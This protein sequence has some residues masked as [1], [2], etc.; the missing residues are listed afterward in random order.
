[1]PPQVRQVLQALR[2]QW[3]RLG[4]TQRLLILALGGVLLVLIVAVAVTTTGPQY[5]T[6][7]RNL[8]EQD[9][10]AIVARLREQRIPFE[11]AEN[12]TAIR[13]PA[14]RAHEIRLQLA[15][16]GLPQGGMI[17]YEIFDRPGLGTLG[18]TEFTQRLNYQ[19]A[20]EGELSRTISRLDPV[21]SARV[22][23]ALPQPALLTER[24][25]EPTAA[26]VLKLRPGRS[27]EPRQVMAIQ[28][29]VSHS[30]EGL[31]PENVTVVTVEGEDLTDL[32][33]QGRAQRP[34]TTLT[35]DQIAVQRQVERTLERNIVQMLEQALGPNRAVV[36]VTVN[37]NWD[38]VQREAE[39][40]APAQAGGQP[41]IVR[42]QQQTRERFS[43]PPG[44]L[45]GGIP[46]VSS[47]VGPGPQTVPGGTAGPP[48]QFE[49][50]DVVTNYEV[51]KAVERLIKAPGSVERISVAVM[52]DGPMDEAQVQAIERTVAAAAG[53][54]PE[55]GDVV[56]VTAL[57]FNRAAMEQQAR[58][59][60]EAQRL[61]FYYNLAKIAAAVLIA[62]LVLLLVRSLLRR[63]VLRRPALPGEEV[64]ALPTGERARPLTR[65]EVPEV[66]SAEEERL[67][68][69]EQRLREAEERRRIIQEHVE[70]LARSQPEAVADLLR[71]WL[72]EE[73]TR[74]PEQPPE[75]SRNNAR[76]RP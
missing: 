75:P 4:R 76:E 56:T 24:Q 28:H 1:M 23:L 45:P 38:Q 19:R 32:G 29:L 42:S 54:K 7:Y 36:R 63:P 50:E 51:S 8:S 69:L 17:G 73:E 65:V 62:V 18:M 39:V 9:A 59:L 52:L 53:V 67:R 70:S 13:V 60:E 47:N 37:L 11:V 33:L 74:P 26:V 48:V 22:H 2:E 21:E 68:A 61:E 14:D 64:S 12:G 15:A 46:G 34:D 6:I 5:T 16:Q 35:R 43:G 40:F 20:L 44:T 3:Q 25:R 10:A 71:T 55:R 41:S 66:P 58:A 49:K 27:L 31:K 30:V 57:P 72:E